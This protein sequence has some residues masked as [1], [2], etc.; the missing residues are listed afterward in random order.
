MVLDIPSVSGL[1][2]NTTVLFLLSNRHVVTLVVNKIN[3]EYKRKLRLINEGNSRDEK[4]RCVVGSCL[5][6]ARLYGEMMVRY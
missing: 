1:E 5:S 6:S 2:G 4:G 3:Q